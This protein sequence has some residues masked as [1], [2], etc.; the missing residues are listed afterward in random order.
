MQ[1]SVTPLVHVRAEDLIRLKSRALA[2]PA[3]V[4]GASGRPGSLTGRNP[5]RGTEIRELR[6]FVDGDDVRFLDASATARTGQ[7]HVRAFFEEQDR[8][9]VLLADFRRPM[10]WGTQ[11]RLRSVA[12][13]EALA[14]AGW[15]VAVTDGN[16]GLVV[17]SDDGGVAL[18]PRARDK[19]MLEIAT[20]L[21]EAHE[22]ARTLVQSSA[23]GRELIHGLHRAGQVA[24]TGATLLV[25]SALDRPGAGFE[26]AVAA[27]LR[28]MSVRILLVEDPFEREAHPGSFAFGDDE[29]RRRTGSFSAAAEVRST[30]IR[31][32]EDAGA[33]VETLPIDRTFGREG[34]HGA[35]G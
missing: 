8:T 19:A 26:M 25:A 35:Q 28:R 11:R 32:L 22:R 20:T 23:P 30:L 9:V 12:A 17:A 5:G 14:L 2:L 18:R 10:L 27:L 15:Q 6:R 7:L 29:G 21:A 34:A 4:P 31:D 16:V 3:I 33:E 1:S 13:A 24:P